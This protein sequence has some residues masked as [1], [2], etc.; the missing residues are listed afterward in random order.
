MRPG[1]PGK[2]RGVCRET[3]TRLSQPPPE[4]AKIIKDLPA[5]YDNMNM[6]SRLIL[7]NRRENVKLLVDYIRTWAGDHGLPA[8]RR[9]SLEKA[10]KEIFHYLV[11]HV[12]RPGQPGSIALALEQKGPRLRLMVEDDAAPHHP[13]GPSSPPTSEGSPRADCFFYNGL[14]QLAESLVYYRTADRKNRLVV[15]LA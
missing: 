8:N 15:F 14:Q 9:R 7:S 6:N 5:S 11:T 10:A 1:K 4:A 13:A 2:F 3:T 12:Y